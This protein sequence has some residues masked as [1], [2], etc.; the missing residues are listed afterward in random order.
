MPKHR[1]PSAPLLLDTH[2]WIWIQTGMPARIQPQILK[3]IQA[4]ADSGELLLSA[5][6]V[7]EVGMLEA[8]GRLQLLMPC[9]QWVNDA[10]NTPGLTLVPLTPEIALDST[11]LPGSFHGDPADR[12]I[13]ATARVMGARLLTLDRSMIEYCRKSG[14]ALIQ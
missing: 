6:S 2:Y 3:A 9:G 11:R 8:K 14:V 7:W 13:L 10:L 4:A 1:L 12:I 5:I